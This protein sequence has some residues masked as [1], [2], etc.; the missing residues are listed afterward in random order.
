MPGSAARSEDAMVSAIESERIE[1][2]RARFGDGNPIWLSR[3]S[4]GQTA[5]CGF[6]H[7]V[8]RA[9]PQATRGSIAVDEDFIEAAPVRLVGGFVAERPFSENA[10]RVAGRL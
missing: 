10:S 3:S 2:R 7:N 9:K 8:L 5:S 4:A 1:I 6:Y